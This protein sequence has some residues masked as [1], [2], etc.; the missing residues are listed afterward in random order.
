MR[1][2]YICLVIT[3]LW[4]GSVLAEPKDDALAVVAQWTA[5]FGAADVD[6][7]TKLYAP[8]A[9][10][11]GTRSQSVVTDAQAIRDYFERALN[12]NR[13]R[14]ATLGVHEVAVLSDTV[15]VVTGL[16]TTTSTREGTTTST[17]GRVTFVV[18]RGDAGW[19]IV[20]FHR[21]AQPSR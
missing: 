13:P 2:L 5:A 21:S 20:H 9:L 6:A 10:F 18:A 3:S 11:M 16:D 15:V 4:C 14:T 17:V 7:I 1:R 19:Q 8:G 12:N